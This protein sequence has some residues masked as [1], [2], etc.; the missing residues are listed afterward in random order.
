MKLEKG[1][2][3]L[4]FRLLIDQKD[5]MVLL[6]ED[7]AKLVVSGKKYQTVSRGGK[8]HALFKRGTLSGVEPQ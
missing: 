8:G 6:K 3:L 5:Q 1:D 4:A 7:G 2:R